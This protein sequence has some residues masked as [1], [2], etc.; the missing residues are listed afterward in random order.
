MFNEALKSTQ[1]NMLT[2]LEAKG[3]KARA[4]HARIRQL[5]GDAKA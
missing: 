2:A 5:V 1:E 3:M 4:F